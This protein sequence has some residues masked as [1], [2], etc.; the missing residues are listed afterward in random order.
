MSLLVARRTEGDQ[1]FL[2]VIAQPTPRLAVMDLKIFHS[3]APLATPAISLQ[4]FLAE[5]SIS[6]R[7]NPQ[8]GPIC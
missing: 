8:A 6:F 3:P 7:I 5:L 1:I 2:Y 4:D